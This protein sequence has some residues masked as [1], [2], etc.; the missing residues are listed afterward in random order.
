MSS[1]FNRKFS[2]ALSNDIIA[3]LQDYWTLTKLITQE[4]IDRI[5]AH[6]PKAFFLMLNNCI[7]SI[8]RSVTAS[9]NPSLQSWWQHYRYH[10]T[11][12]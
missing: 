4:K 7:N 6:F 12:A 2:K 1:M 5:D 3:F 10:A 8:L 9:A 11:C